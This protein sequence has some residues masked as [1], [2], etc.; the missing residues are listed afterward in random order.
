MPR[1]R[2]F[3]LQEAVLPRSFGLRFAWIASLPSDNIGSRLPSKDRRHLRS[4]PQSKSLGTS[5][6]LLDGRCW[7]YY[8]QWPIRVR[9]AEPGVS[10]ME[11]LALMKKLCMISVTLVPP[12]TAM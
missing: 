10:L 4:W 12:A 2:R 11:L 8:S 7:M 9:L 1:N 3:L 5:V 6:D